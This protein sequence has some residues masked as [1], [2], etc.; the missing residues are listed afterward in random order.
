MWRLSYRLLLIKYHD[1]NL[2]PLIVKSGFN[3][4]P[5]VDVKFPLPCNILRKYPTEVVRKKT[6]RHKIP[7]IHLE[8]K[9]QFQGIKSLHNA[10]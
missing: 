6:F 10:Q 1:S 8:G 5:D 7:T 2:E 3:Y 9:V 4:V